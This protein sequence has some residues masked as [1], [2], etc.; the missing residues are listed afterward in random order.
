[1][2]DFDEKEYNSV[3]LG[4]LLHDI[5]KFLHRLND[6]KYPYHISHQDTSYNFINK[7][8][9]KFFNKNLYDIDLVEVLVRYHHGDKKKNKKQIL[10]DDPYIKELDP[11]KKVRVWDLIK[12]VQRAD[13]YS[14]YERDHTISKRDRTERR[15]PLDAIFSNINLSDKIDNNVPIMRYNLSDIH[16]LKA[17]P[18][19]IQ[20]LEESD[21]AKFVR[22]FNEEILD[23]NKFS[24]FEDV[25]IQWINILQK[26]TW[27][28]PSDT[29]YEHSDVSLFD[30]LKSSAAIA[31]CLYKHHFSDIGK[32]R[33]STKNEF[34]FIAG[35]FSGIQEYIFHITNQGSGGAAKRLRA[36]S[37]F[38]TLF[39]ET[40]IHR[41]VHSLEL[42]LLCNLFSA[43]GK[44]MI[45]APKQE[46][47]EGTL[48]EL[49]NEIESHIHR[50]FFSQFSFLMTWA[51]V[52]K[53]KQKFKVRNFY[54]TADEMF[55]NL[56]KQKVNKTLSVFKNEKLCSWEPES[57]K[58]T[59]LYGSYNETGDCPICGRGP[60]LL[61]EKESEPEKEA[62][63][64]CATC[65]MDKYYI[66]E[67]LPRKRY[68]GFGKGQQSSEDRTNR[69]IAL[70]HDREMMHLSNEDYFFEFLDAI[71][72]KKTEYYL[73]YDIRP[74]KTNKAN[75]ETSLTVLGKRIANHVPTDQDGSTLEFGEI[76]KRSIWKKDEKDFGSPLLGVLKVD[77]DNLGL[78]FSKGFEISR[79]I[80]E[81]KLQPGDRKT[82]SRYLTFSRMIE[83]FMSGWIGSAMNAK[84]QA[85]MLHELS[86]SL[87]QDRDRFDKY[88]QTA[89][90]NFEDIYTVYSGGDDLVLIG[91]WETMI[92]FSMVLYQQFNKFISSNPDI[93]LS[94]GL[95]FVKPKQPIAS[96]IKEANTLL[97][98]SKKEGKK[99]ITLFNTTMEWETFIEIEPL[100]ITLNEAVE[101][102]NQNKLKPFIYRLLRYRQMA[103][104]YLVEKE[105]H[106]PN[107]KYISLM[108]Y[109][110]GRNILDRDGKRPP[111]ITSDSFSL[112][113]KLLQE[114]PEGMDSLIN[115]IGIP[116]S[117]VIYRIR[118]Y[119]Q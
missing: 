47:I 43:A 97:E 50:K 95:A 118:R 116:I 32:G 99:R 112:L 72:T 96:A 76:A 22:Q 88:I 25:L 4:A 77:I 14:C 29:R 58:A 100:F 86:N 106:I 113:V 30:H 73:F 6:K 28:I 90:I 110:F 57:F 115:L 65:Y 54:K 2:N 83:L 85:G 55:F 102:D 52:G 109:D 33:L 34:I 8:K 105:K 38:I 19:D 67:Q 82:V 21:Y 31:A 98:Q 111:N 103:T 60:A 93:T 64:C 84:N 36:R 63:R 79:N 12:I 10:A 62:Q 71:P 35:D 39:S 51:D 114:K 7:N 66:G 17:F 42:P 75:K 108:H 23:F 59:E 61:K 27:V 45:I 53:Y 87:K 81:K 16:P 68:I 74:D 40:V 49:R 69:I 18:V 91:P 11:D 48:K 92:I 94:A 101:K 119:N 5:G 78:L 70:K 1:M 117:W 89:K 3:I 20:L 15:A 9:K 80:S 104:I 13:V 56:E 24:R 41:I 44:F 26:Y 37:L 46:G 107:L